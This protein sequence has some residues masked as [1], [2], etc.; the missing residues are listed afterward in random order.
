M[1]LKGK[2]DDAASNLIDRKL[3]FNKGGGFGPLV[4]ALKASALYTSAARKLRQ[5]NQWRAGHAGEID[6][7]SIG[8]AVGNL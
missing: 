3:S 7:G 8:R 1:I 6:L 4:D 5:D 2:S